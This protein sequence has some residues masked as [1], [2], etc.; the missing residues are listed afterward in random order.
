MA[1]KNGNG[2]GNGHVHEDVAATG[3]TAEAL[4]ITELVQLQVL[5]AFLVQKLG[6]ASQANVAEKMAELGAACDEHL[7]HQALEGLRGRGILSYA[8]GRKPEGQV[9]AFY[10]MRRAEYAPSLEIAHITDLLPRLV[11]TP[12][13]KALMAE[14][15]GEEAEV[16]EGEQ[17]KTRALGY[18]QYVAV[19]ATF[20]TLT[21]LVGSQP[22]SPW[23][24]ELVARSAKLTGLPKIDA[25]LRFWRDFATGLPQLPS[26]A[27]RG[28]IRT[29]LRSAGFSDAVAGYVAVSDAVIDVDKKD[30]LQGAFPVID[31]RTREGK[32]LTTCELIAPKQRVTVTFRIPTRGFMS[33]RQF[34]LWLAAYAPNPI[35]GC[36]PARGA[37][38]GKMVMIKFEELGALTDATSAL[39]SVMSDAMPDEAKA[40]YAQCLAEAANVDLR[41]GK[42][43]S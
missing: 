10:R 21:E 41:K 14:L 18:E 5:T 39:Q 22:A 17:K 7:L 2:N 6:K 1:T 9:A 30:F 36:S 11:A 13:A 12:E 26:D 25:Q 34:K 35:R 19:R 24:D 42:D 31:P 15:N 33:A 8:S 43:A 23:L 16:E 20:L 38:F 32:G 37:R 40:F 3:A 4:P 28:W 29:G 27:L